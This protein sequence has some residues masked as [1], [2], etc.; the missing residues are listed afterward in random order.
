V[1]DLEDGFELL[2]QWPRSFRTGDLAGLE[3][4]TANSSIRQEPIHPLKNG[5]SRSDR[6]ARERA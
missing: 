3:T 4:N 2:L 6:P 5:T 1:N